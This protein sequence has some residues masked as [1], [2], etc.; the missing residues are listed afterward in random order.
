MG[1]VMPELQEVVPKYLQVANHYR[2]LILSGTLKPGDEVPSER[3]IADQWRIARPT[4]TRALAALR[5]Q[6][7]VESRQGAGT[8]VR[9]RV[10][11]HRR[12]ADRYLRARKAGHIYP[13]DEYAEIVAAERTA[14][15]DWVT[16]CLD[17]KVPDAIR[18]QRITNGLDGPIEVSTSWFDASLAAIAP[19]L[20]ER[21]RIRE[22]TVAYVEDLTGRRVSYARDQ[23]GARIASAAERR[24][25]GV[26]SRTA[27]V[28]V[29]RHVVYDTAD[30]PFECVEAVYPSDRWTFEQEY[31]VQD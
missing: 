29:V 10:H 16:E 24:Q 25:L 5:N 26:T 4:A 21:S 13:T 20:L 31:Q 3:Q 12:A 6:G 8:Y 7:L 17:L 30:R 9:D 15:P 1:A 19:R 22:G 27:A 23:I 28:L 11:F 2:D 18:R 14:A